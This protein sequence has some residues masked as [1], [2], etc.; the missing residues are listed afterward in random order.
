[1]QPSSEDVQDMTCVVCLS[2]P[3]SV[4]FDPCQHRSL[5][6]DCFLQ[7]QERDETTCPVCRTPILNYMHDTKKYVQQMSVEEYQRL[8]VSYTSQELLKLFK[9][10]RDNPA[11]LNKLEQCDRKLIE[12]YI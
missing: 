6:D 9:H 5:C 12:Q 4:V 7:W 10:I 11:E 2:N 8:G 3:S 1:M